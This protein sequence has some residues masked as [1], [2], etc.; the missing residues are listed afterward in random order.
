MAE[1]SF[2][3]DSNEA[4]LQD[5]GS[6]RDVEMSYTP[7]TRNE[8]S[9]E[10]ATSFRDESN[11]TTVINNVNTPGEIPNDHQPLSDCEV[12]P[13]DIRISLP[14]VTCSSKSTADEILIITA[15]A[16]SADEENNSTS[17]MNET[18]FGEQTA[19][20]S[21]KY[22]S[23]Q[24]SRH[25]NGFDGSAGKS[26]VETNSDFTF[27]STSK[28][29]FDK[30]L[31]DSLEKPNIV[32]SYD[33]NLAEGM[34]ESLDEIVVELVEELAQGVEELADE[35]DQLVE[36]AGEPSAGAGISE[37]SYRA[38]PEVS[39]DETEDV[40]DESLGDEEQDTENPIVR[41]I[42]SERQTSFQ[43]ELADAI[44]RLAPL[45]ELEV[46]KNNTIVSLWEKFM[47]KLT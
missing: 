15:G 7:L 5:D 13:L 26:N 1:Q 11:S 37:A 4:S 27:A 45:E 20:I 24:A 14:P 29:F 32:S 12:M 41:P 44:V 42:V 39:S 9:C 17:S 36:L 28:K 38:T 46:D 10:S 8:T 19:E 33:S 16:V 18:I 6:H 47:S 43:R 21:E 31:N 22:F 35:V 3:A 34:R 2:P 30:S 40:E 25:C 23:R